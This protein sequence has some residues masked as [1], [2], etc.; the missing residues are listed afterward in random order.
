MTAMSGL[1]TFD[2][3]LARRRPARRPAARRTRGTGGRRDGTAIWGAAARRARR[4]AAC[5]RR[6]RRQ[7]QGAARRLA[8][9]CFERREP[10]AVGIANRLELLTQAGRAPDAP[11]A[12]RL[13]R[14]GRRGARRWASARAPDRNQDR[15]M[16]VA[17][18]VPPNQ[19]REIITI[20]SSPTGR[21]N[22]SFPEGNSP[23]DKLIREL[24]V[25]QTNEGG[26]RPEARTPSGQTPAADSRGRSPRRASSSQNF[27][28]TAGST[29]A[30]AEDPTVH[31]VQ[32]VV[33]LR[34]QTRS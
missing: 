10:R 21:T 1:K 8:Q 2:V 32:C 17:H 15:A 16:T 30:S 18:A 9:P 6:R 12:D 24:N 23:R 34:W 4:S 14:C 31:V 28:S 22:G 19:V 13:L 25:V 20:T 26:A 33:D 27:A 5:G 3:A 11:A 29:A 7:P